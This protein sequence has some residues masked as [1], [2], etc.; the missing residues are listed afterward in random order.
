MTNH[1]NRARIDF[2]VPCSPSIHDMPKN[3][4]D[5]GVKIRHEIQRLYQQISYEAGCD[6]ITQNVRPARFA[7]LGKGS[8][9]VTPSRADAAQKAY[10]DLS[11]AYNAWAKTASRSAPYRADPALLA[12]VYRS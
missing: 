7:A 8:P 9:S 10:D 11:E 3:V 12:Q 5:A 6:H 4:Q 1:P 2:V